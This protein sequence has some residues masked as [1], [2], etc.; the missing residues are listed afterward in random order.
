GCPGARAAT[1]AGTALERRAQTVS[2]PADPGPAATLTDWD[3]EAETKIVAAA[4]YAVTE[5]PDPELLTMARAMTPEKR[6]KIM[7][8]FV[9]D[10]ANRRHKPEIGRAHV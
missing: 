10:R 7:A 3:P 6:A 8:A 5:R 9:G 4:L 1:R 2:E